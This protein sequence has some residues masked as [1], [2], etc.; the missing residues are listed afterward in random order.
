MCFTGRCH[1]RR[2]H[3]YYKH[4]QTRET[5]RTVTMTARFGAQYPKHEAINWLIVYIAL[6]MCNDSFCVTKHVNVAASFFFTLHWEKTGRGGWCGRV[7]CVLR[8][9]LPLALGSADRHSPSPLAAWRHICK[10]SDISTNVRN[11]IHCTEYADRARLLA[12]TSKQI[13]GTWIAQSVQRIDYG[14]PPGRPARSQSLY[15]LSYRGSSPVQGVLPN[16]D[17][18]KK[19]KKRPKSK[20]LYSYRERQKAEI[21]K[22]SDPI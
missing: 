17:K 2:T 3:M 11:G 20:G 13:S 5:L 10:K 15:R 4:G 1:C 6:Y 21:V 7:H 12:N 8:G 22:C 9:F 19:L 14:R 18:V 16:M